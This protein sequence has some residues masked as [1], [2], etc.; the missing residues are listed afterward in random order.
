[1]ERFAGL[2]FCGFQEYHESFFMNIYY[3]YKLHL[4][5]LFN[6]FKCKA[7]QKFSHENFIGLD[8]RKFS[9]ANLSTFTVYTKNLNSSGGFRWLEGVDHHTQSI[10]NYSQ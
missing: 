5:A 9:S 7:L 8:P 3:I 1:M 2:D 10:I 6:Y 4:M